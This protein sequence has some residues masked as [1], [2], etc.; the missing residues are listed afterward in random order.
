M[1]RIIAYKVFGKGGESVAES[2][3]LFTSG[4]ESKKYQSAATPPKRN[5]EACLALFVFDSDKIDDEV[6][7][8]YPWYAQGELLKA[9]SKALE[10]E[11]EWTAIPSPIR[12]CHGELFEEAAF[13]E[14]PSVIV[15]RDWIKAGTHGIDATHLDSNFA[16]KLKLAQWLD[17]IPYVVGVGAIQKS[18]ALGAHKELKGR[19]IIGYLGLFTLSKAPSL[20]NVAEE[21]HLPVETSAGLME[22]RGSKCKGWLAS[23]EAFREAGLERVKS[24]PF[25]A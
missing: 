21:L 5:S 2:K 6:S 16:G 12:A 15:L 1:Q 14:T 25:V 23:E 13:G 19:N 24:G 17:Q 8:P 10:P 18:Y 3:G 7:G 4:K 22:I 20:V 11:G 9:L